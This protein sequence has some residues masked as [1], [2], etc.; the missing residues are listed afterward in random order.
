MTQG[1]RNFFATCLAMLPIPFLKKR[2][3]AIRPGSLLC[4]A[5]NGIYE[6]PLLDPMTSNEWMLM[7]SNDASTVWQVRNI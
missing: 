3:E 5:S 6:I 1:R 2:E 7:T 4:F